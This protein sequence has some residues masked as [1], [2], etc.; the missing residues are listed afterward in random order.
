VK[1]QVERS[2]QDPATVVTTYEGHHAHPSPATHH[3]V[4]TI[5]TARQ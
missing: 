5:A 2:Q 3:G 1:K 4:A